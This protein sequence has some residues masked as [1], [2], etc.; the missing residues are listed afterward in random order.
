MGG[1]LGQYG[2]CLGRG[3]CPSRGKGGGGVMRIMPLPLFPLPPPV[4]MEYGTPGDVDPFPKGT[5]VTV[6]PGSGP[7]V[8][9]RRM[10]MYCGQVVSR[11]DEE[12][13]AV[14]ELGKE[15]AAKKGKRV[16]RDKMTVWTEPGSTSGS[17]GPRYMDMSEEVWEK[18][19]VRAGY[20]VP[21]LTCPP[22]PP[23]RYMT[24]RP[25]PRWCWWW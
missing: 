5:R 23:G 25:H 20:E 17:R 12:Y 9:P 7:D 14:Y 4:I 16:H 15:R 18:L 13:Y 1:T 19:R 10:A 24:S 3:T 6:I 11:L 2:G 22:P 21:P 8:D